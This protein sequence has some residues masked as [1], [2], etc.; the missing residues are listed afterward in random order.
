MAVPNYRGQGMNLQ[1]LQLASVGQI[2][3]ADIEFGDLTVLVGPQATGKSIFLQLFRLVV[4]TGHVHDEMR[5]H[6]LD[7]KRDVP[8][9][10]SV[11]LGEGMESLWK[12]GGT[13]TQDENPVGKESAERLWP[14]SETRSCVRVNGKEVKFAEYVTPRHRVT[15]SYLFYIPAQRVLTLANGW[16]RPFSAYGAGDPFAVRDFSEQ[17]RLMM[18]QEFGRGESVF[19]KRNRL[20]AEYRQLL[21]EHVFAGFSLCLDTYGAQKRLVLRQGESAKDIPYMVWSAGQREFVPLLLGMYWLMPPARVSRRDKVEWVVIEEPE[22]GLHPQA[23]SVVLLLLL[24][25]VSRGYRVC[26]STHSPHVLDVVWALNVIRE[27]R[28]QP[29]AILDIF[30][31]RR[32]DVTRK[33]AASVSNKRAKVYFFDRKSGRTH[34]ISNLDPGS[35][36]VIEAGWGGLT[37]FSGRVGEVVSKIVSGAGG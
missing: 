10:L 9:F 11:Y 36:N 6:G 17:F 7:W 25:I 30:D 37:A 34:D 13:R 27:H 5:K 35:E 3:E 23:I 26:V 2:K 4:D 19:P 24:E 8:G 33:V 21:T 1:R 16:P 12:Q 28:A 18:E 31:A 29:E 32:S 15:A 14:Q 22:M 20:K